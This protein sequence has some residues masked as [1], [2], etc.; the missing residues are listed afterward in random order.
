M[1]EASKKV[2]RLGI[3][4]FRRLPA[5]IAYWWKRNRSVTARL[6]RTIPVRKWKS[7]EFGGENIIG[8]LAGFTLAR[9]FEEEG[10]THIHAPWAMGPATAAWAASELTGIPF[11][12]TGRACD[13]Y[14]PDGALAEKLR[15]EVCHVR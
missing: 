14:P 2:E 4:F 13:I 12:F 3:P 10:I 15:R 5:D 6:F 7:I 9:R 11:S 8:F 1:A